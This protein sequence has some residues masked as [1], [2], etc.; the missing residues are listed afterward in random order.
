MY[1][2]FN[3]YLKSIEQGN[4]SCYPD[5]VKELALLCVFREREI[6]ELWFRMASTIMD[7]VN[8]K[9]E[10]NLKQAVSN[11]VYAA[12]LWNPDLHTHMSKEGY[13]PSPQAGDYYDFGY[14]REYGQFNYL[15]DRK[16]KIYIQTVAMFETF[17]YYLMNVAVKDNY[18]W[19]T[20]GL[21]QST[22]GAYEV[23]DMLSK[24]Y[25]VHID[26]KFYD[27]LVDGKDFKHDISHQIRLMDEYIGQKQYLNIL[28]NGK[29]QYLQPHL[30][31]LSSKTDEY[32]VTYSADGRYL[33]SFSNNQLTEYRIKDGTC[34]MYNFKPDNQ[35]KKLVIPS[36]VVIIGDCFSC[37]ELKT[38]LIEGN[39]LEIISA[40]AFS[41]CPKL[42]EIQL[43]DSVTSIDELAFGSC[44][45]PVFQ[46]GKNILSL[47]GGNDANDTNYTYSFG[48]E[49]TYRIEVHADNPNFCCIDGMLFSKDKK[50]LYSCPDGKLLKEKTDTLHI[51]E[52]TEILFSS[53][54][55]SVA[56]LKKLVLPSTI[57]RLGNDFVSRSDKKNIKIVCYASTPPIIDGKYTYKNLRFRVPDE[58][59]EA[60]EPVKHRF[61][62]ILGLN[63]PDPYLSAILF[64][65]NGLGNMNKLFDGQNPLPAKTRVATAEDLCSE[66]MPEEHV[67]ITGLTIEMSAEDMDIIRR[68]HIPECMEDHWFMYCDEDTI[69]YF[70]SW[71]G[72]PVFEAR[73]EKRGDTYYVTELVV[74]DKPQYYVSKETYSFYHLFL[75]LLFTETGHDSTEHWNN[76]IR[77]TEV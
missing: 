22:F 31:I 77:H 33:I 62:Y 13:Y 2:E 29:R 41:E 36:S 49:E 53:S 58:F 35:L 69:R 15:S 60:Y 10:C 44:C 18:H 56:G 25:P 72:I 3:N 11:W 59:S 34:L 8:I 6:P 42:S 7:Y 57:K 73:Y 30:F 65:K 28:P 32:G 37:N 67:T 40:F 55:E 47:T 16:L 66:P 74:N 54:L 24:K 43:P 71:S 19:S 26:W 14:S 1:T 70:R 21:K 39:G 64:W 4:P 17:A 45:I 5:C 46:V 38:V 48:N 63:E 27:I 61:K 50:T 76:Y 52:G 23:W 20:Y 9:V 51:P 68:G 12:N 75:Y